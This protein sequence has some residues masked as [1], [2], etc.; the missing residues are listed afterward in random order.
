MASLLVLVFFLL[1]CTG[2]WL[3]LEKL[4]GDRDFL[5]YDDPRTMDW[6]SSRA[7]RL[8]ISKADTEDKALRTQTLSK[9]NAVLIH[10]EKDLG[11]VINKE[12]LLRIQKIENSIK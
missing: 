10:S 8:A 5:V 2:G 9:W 7:A 6:D 1:A 11:N 12:S 4:G 3:K